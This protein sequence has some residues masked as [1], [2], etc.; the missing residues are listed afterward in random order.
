M[1]NS[2]VL[3]TVLVQDNNVHQRS[4]IINIISKNSEYMKV[5]KSS[6]ICQLSI[7]VYR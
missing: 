5:K 6:I 4:R 1:S 7:P 2:N 3:G